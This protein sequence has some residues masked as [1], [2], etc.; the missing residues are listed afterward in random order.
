MVRAVATPAGALNQHG[1]PGLAPD[2]VKSIRYAVSHAVG[3]QAASEGEPGGLST[4]LAGGTRTRQNTPA[5][6]QTARR[7]GWVVGGVGADEVRVVDHRVDD[8]LT[9]VVGDARRVAAQDHRQ[10][11]GSQPDA[12]QRPDV[13]V[14]QR[15]RPNVDRYPVGGYVRG[16]DLADG[17][18]APAGSWRQVVDLRRRAASGDS[19]GH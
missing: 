11:I 14:I 18:A 5:A 4:R 6:P 3:R 15:G 9:A 7:A 1:V 2:C 10:P 13:V 17:Q 12:P 19:L 8:H 16:P